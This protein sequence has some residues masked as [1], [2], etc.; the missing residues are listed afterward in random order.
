MTSDER[1]E[2]I[3]LCTAMQAERDLTK[4]LAIV[5]QLNVLLDRALA[6]KIADLVREGSED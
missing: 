2:M 4:I 3:R 6:R 5:Q 1:V